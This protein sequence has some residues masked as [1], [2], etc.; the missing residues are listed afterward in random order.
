[1]T[2]EKA[3]NPPFREDLKLSFRALKV[4]YRLDHRYFWIQVFNSLGD[5]LRYYVN[6]ILA[7]LIIDGVV[8]GADP[9]KLGIYAILVVFLNLGMNVMVQYTAAR[10]Y[11]RKSMWPKFITRFFHGYSEKMDYWRF[12][13]PETRKLWNRIQK[14]IGN[15]AGISN[16]AGFLHTLVHA[17]VGVTTALAV[18]IACFLAKPTVEVH[19]I[20]RLINSPWMLIIFFLLSVF[21]M[22]AKAKNETKLDSITS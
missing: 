2:K 8:A 12:E 7:A 16:I 14:H 4:L 11:I 9:K 20:V 3:K 19:G 22:L 10:R 17:I 1:M 13:D 5:S 15:T 18:M 21:I 6:S